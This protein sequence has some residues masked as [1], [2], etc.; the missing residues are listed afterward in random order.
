MSLAL[1]FFAPSMNS[2]PMSNPNTPYLTYFIFLTPVP[3]YN[4]RC[5]TVLYKY[6]A[7]LCSEELADLADQQHYPLL[8]HHSAS[9]LM[10]MGV[11]SSKKPSP[12]SASCVAL[13][14]ITPNSTF[15]A[16]TSAATAADTR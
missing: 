11:L 6:H 3:L 7:E 15:S 4:F 2:A 12:D 9:S 8:S 16:L 10:G 13:E 1:S 5:H 14:P